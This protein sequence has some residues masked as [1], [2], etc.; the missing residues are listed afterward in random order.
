MHE[1]EKDNETILK[2]NKKDDET[3][4]INLTH[5]IYLYIYIIKMKSKI[6]FA[7][8]FLLIIDF[9]YNLQDLANINEI[10]ENVYYNLGKDG[11]FQSASKIYQSLKNKRSPK[12]SLPVIKKWLKS[13]DDYTLQK[14]ARR[15]SDQLL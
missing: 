8:I 4:W 14:T 12:I 7:N 9:S 1:V 15:K 10:L 11:A 6:I 3:I 5:G 2:K 13:K